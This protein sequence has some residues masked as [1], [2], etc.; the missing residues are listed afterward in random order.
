MIAQQWKDKVNSFQEKLYSYKSVKEIPSKWI[1][2]NIFLPKEVSRYNGRMSYDVAPYCREIVDCLHP[3][4]PTRIIAV[5]KSAQ[6]GITQ[7]LVVPGMA[8]IISENP[9]NFLFTAGDKDLAKKTIRERFD[10]IMQASN[11]KHLIRPNTIRSKGQRS[12]D[13]DLS[14]EFAGGSAII[15]GTNNAGKFRFFSVKTVFMDDFD[16]APK[17]DKKEGS[18]V[19]LVEARQTSFGNLSKMFLISTPTETQTSNIYESY[20]KGD[21]RKWH[22]LCEKCEGW[23]PT[24]FQI[25]LVNNKRAGIVWETD[26]NNKLIKNSVRYKCPHCGH[27]V[28]QKSKHEL[29]QQGDWIATA[30]A[31][32]ENYKSYYINSLIIPAGFFSWS[33]LVKE[34]LEACPPKKP[35]NVDMLKAFYNVRLGL[36]FEER[37]EAPKI[38]QL[39]KNTGKYE[40]GEI[41]DELSKEDGNGEIVF[42]SLA[43]DLGGI[44][45]TDED[46][47]D[48]RIDWAISAY[49]ANGVKYSIDQG[50]I[51]TF[52]RKHTKSK[53]EI[54]SDDQR[55]K[56]T[57]MHGQKNS[58]WPVLE[59]IIKSDFIGQSGTEYI[60]S[61]SIIDTGHFTR[62]ADQFIGMFDGNNPVYGIKGRSDKKF[63]S[64]SKDTPAVK[65]SR[66]NPKLYIAEVDQ[67]KDELASYM[68]LRK[69]DDGTQPPGFMN[70]PTPRDGK[71]SFKDYFK[72]FESEQRKEVKENGQVVGYKWDKKTTMIENHFWDVEIYNIA[73][74]YI[75]MDLIKRS[76]PSK[77]RHLDWAS[78]VEFVGE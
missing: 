28:S 50:A 69:T 13:T 78:F 42:I 49:A 34:F 18:I 41:P 5:M 51:G 8:Y 63:R 45:N 57:Y 1:E 15:E 60:I 30:E 12:G 73:A 20:L 23:M 55:K 74:P 16:A 65:R 75:Y 48:V 7:G 40:I 61:I 33:D 25:N 46:I 47:E 6:S 43:A 17:S 76:N 31:I 53:K 71:Y 72:H 32:E 2:D 64:E 62:Y 68:K 59:K 19:K 10:N 66:E 26:E 14:K 67:L 24:D 22:W 27:K 36:P 9:D 56:F 39:M 21:Q 3:S 70:F 35:V 52:K 38:M 29:N 37:G 4:D 77:F 54:E 11:L 58:V 44:M